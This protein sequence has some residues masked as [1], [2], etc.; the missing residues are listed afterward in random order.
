MN[1]SPAALQNSISIP[2]C[3]WPIERLEYV[4]D[5]IK[6]I[7]SWMLWGLL[8]KFTGSHPCPTSQQFRCD[9]CCHQISMSQKI[10]AKKLSL[11]SFSFLDQY[12]H[13]SIPRSQNTKRSAE[14]GTG[15]SPQQSNAPSSNGAVDGMW[16]NMVG[17]WN[18]SSDASET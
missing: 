6:P 17:E 5:L 10:A 7:H 13:V 11:I 4:L 16:G 3:L 14:S 15:S 2:V 12:V 18:V 9:Q 1:S 8:N